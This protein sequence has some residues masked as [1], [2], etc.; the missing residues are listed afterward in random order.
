LLAQVHRLRNSEDFSLTVRRGRKAGGP[1]VAVHLLDEPQAHVAPQVGFVVS[2]AVGSAA[3]RNRVKR[4]LRHLMR[5]RVTALPPGARLVVRALPSSSHVSS[6]SLA[7]DLDQ[8]LG[9]V[10][11]R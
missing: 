3:E 7:A 9:Q 10:G 6:R 1:V 2:K 11:V 8:A 5:D 4:Q